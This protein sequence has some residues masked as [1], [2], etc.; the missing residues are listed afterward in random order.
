MA[1]IDV[2]R[3]TNFISL[4][5]HPANNALTVTYEIFVS[6]VDRKSKQELARRSKRDQH[7]IHI[8]ALDQ[9]NESDLISNRLTIN[10]QELS[11]QVI[12]SCPLLQSERHNLED[13][14]LHLLYLVNRRRSQLL[15]GL[16]SDSSAQDKSPSAGS[17]RVNS[18]ASSGHQTS[19]LRYGSRTG[20]ASVR[21]RGSLVASASSSGYKDVYTYLVAK[22]SSSGT[23]ESNE[24]DEFLSDFDQHLSV[25]EAERWPSSSKYPSKNL[26]IPQELEHLLEELYG[27]V[28]EREES[29]CKIRILS[30]LDENLIHITSNSLLICAMFRTLRDLDAKSNYISES[31]LYLILKISSYSDTLESLFSNASEQIDVF[32]I[33]ADLLSDHSKLLVASN[34]LT[35]IVSQFYLT[36]SLLLI[37][38]NSIIF[39]P[40]HRLDRRSSDN[41]GSKQISIKQNV[42]QLVELICALCKALSKNLA[43]GIRL[44]VSSLRITKVFA[45]LVRLMKRISVFSECIKQFRLNQNIHFADSLVNALNCL[46]LSRPGSGMTF[47]ERL[48]YV[49]DKTILNEIYELE[50]DILRV[51]N[52]FLFDQKVKQRL[53]RKNILRCVLRN[54]VVFLASRK[55]NTLSPFNRSSVLIIPF[56]CLYELSC[57]LRVRIELFKSKI[58]IKCLLE[59]LLSSSTQLK[60]ALSLNSEKYS[61]SGNDLMRSTTTQ[62]D[63]FQVVIQPN[64]ADYYVVATWINVSACKGATFYLDNTEVREPFCEYFELAISNL[65]SLLYSEGKRTTHENNILV[66]IHLKLM[67]NLSQFMDFKQEPMMWVDP[68]MRWIDLL[69]S[70]I[71]RSLNSTGDGSAMMMMS[72]ECVAIWTNW[73]Q[74][75]GQF[76]SLKI[77]P[78]ADWPKSTKNVFVALF[79]RDLRDL[80]AEVDDLM[81]VAI[82]LLGA[83]AKCCEICDELNELKPSIVS[84]FN[85]IFE[86]KTTDN[87][88][89]ICALYAMTQLLNHTTILNLF[90]TSQSPEDIPVKK[91]VQNLCGFLLHGDSTIAG[92]ADSI[93]VAMRQLDEVSSMTESLV[94]YMRFI[95]YNNRW[96]NAIQAHMDD[97]I[98]SEDFEEHS[99]SSNSAGAASAKTSSDTHLADSEDLKQ[100]KA[101]SGDTNLSAQTSSQHQSHRDGTESS[102]TKEDE[103]NHALDMDDDDDELDYGDEDNFDEPDL[104]VIDAKSMIKHLTTRKE[105]RSRWLEQ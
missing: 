15:A 85:F 66:F 5:T 70:S 45:I 22:E 12:K 51:V 26:N 36:N 97:G 102:S 80:D 77:I 4:D 24:S 20:S 58:I 42:H 78:T 104:N 96:L 99:K 87:E 19:K 31:I 8:S 74:R 49:Q 21:R 25:V 18:S 2:N 46:Q 64:S 89:V 83:L 94:H 52:N 28:E 92:L 65:R 60:Y 27:S 103:E 43:A 37:L 57:S 75:K 56:K 7:Q 29:I 90:S 101:F 68:Y 6:V 88:M 86:S 81:L 79:Q 39:S 72:V 76:E 62:E 32:R 44:P 91:L 82:N 55:S 11:L 69:G 3:T 71:E 17:A 1:E 34:E 13:I 67:R 35:F 61:A 48:D 50:L 30:H 40:S 93:L 14:Q 47:N 54:L 41:G 59:Y 16:T 33:L 100:V 10:L 105:F 63:E 9:L 84:T 98:G 73:I 53:I 38:E 23:T 95:A